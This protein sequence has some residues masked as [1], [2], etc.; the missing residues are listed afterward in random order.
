MWY[1]KVDCEFSNNDWQVR[2]SRSI[3]QTQLDT[4]DWRHFFY[5]CW[6]ALCLHHKQSSFCRPSPAASSPSAG[7]QRLSTAHSWRNRLH[8]RQCG[9]ISPDSIGCWFYKWHLHLRYMFFFYMSP[10]RGYVFLTFV[11][12]NHDV[13]EW[14]IWVLGRTKEEIKPLMLDLGTALVLLP[15]QCSRRSM[16]K[17]SVFWIRGDSPAKRTEEKKSVLRFRTSCAAQPTSPLMHHI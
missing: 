12:Q 15:L 10:A 14:C 11:Q 6:E 3:T 17:V 1:T 7:L 5:W 8:F 13:K 9:N 2:Q 16:G 4:F